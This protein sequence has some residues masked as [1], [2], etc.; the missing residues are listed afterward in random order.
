V[1][2]RLAALLLLGAALAA[3]PPPAGGQTDVGGG[4]HPGGVTIRIV[5]FR[6]TERVHADGEGASDGCHYELAD[7]SVLPGARPPADLTQP[8]YRLLLCN[9]FPDRWVLVGPDSVV[10]LEVEARQRVEEYV[11]TIPVPTLSVSIN[12]PGAGLTGLESWFWASGYR[13]G[14]ITERIEVFDVAVD[15]RIAPTQVT[16]AFGD[17]ASV[18]GDLGRPYPERSTITHV[19]TNRSTYEVRASMALRPSYRVDGTEWQFLA[20]IPVGGRATYPV[21]EVQ[22]VITTG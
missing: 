15:V 3:A 13:G 4:S 12:P 5:R 20:D 7:L 6:G 18:T 2:R 8:R 22:A 16:W 21:H 17:G 1:H 11:Q 10:D 19:Y 9:G 14:V